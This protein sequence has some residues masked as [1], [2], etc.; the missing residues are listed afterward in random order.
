MRA[1]IDR[2]PLLP[3]EALAAGLI[4]GLAY[5]A[6]LDANG[7]LLVTGDTAA[8]F[9]WDDEE[10]TERTFEGHT[11]HTGDLF[12]LDDDGFFWF[13]GRVDDLI[14]VG[15]IWVAPAGPPC[16]VESMTPGRNSIASGRG[17]RRKA[18]SS[19]WCRGLA[20]GSESAPTRAR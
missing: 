17:W 5:E 15:G 4:D 19:C 18:R 16:V 10:K 7:E 6:Q 1:L 3:S 13:R 20:S 2:A 14:K 12:E 9:Y 8:L 11:V